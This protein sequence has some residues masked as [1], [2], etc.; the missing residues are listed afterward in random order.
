[1]STLSLSLCIC[2]S[3]T[4]CICLLGKRE[5][6]KE[7]GQSRLLPIIESRTIITLTNQM[8]SRLLAVQFDSLQFIFNTSLEYKIKQNKNKMKLYCNIN[9]YIFC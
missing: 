1:M 4:L 9:I 8:N 5:R 7:W 6:E 3:L 2:L